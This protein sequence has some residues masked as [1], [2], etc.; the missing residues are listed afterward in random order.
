M[1]HLMVGIAVDDESFQCQFFIK[2]NAWPTKA[3][4]SRIDQVAFSGAAHCAFLMKRAGICAI[5]RRR[6]ENELETFHE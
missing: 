6:N 3:A 5:R 4:L 2:A 1:R